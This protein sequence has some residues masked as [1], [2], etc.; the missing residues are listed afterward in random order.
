MSTGD[1]SEYVRGKIAERGV[2][3]TARFMRDGFDRWAES[4]QPAREGQMEKIPAEQQMPAVGGAMTLSKARKLYNNN[5][6]AKHGAGFKE[7]LDKIK[8]QVTS[9]LNVYRKISKFIDDFQQD[10]KDEI[11]ENPEVAASKPKLVNFAN[12]L[13]GWLESIKVYKNVLD[14]IAKMAESYGMGRKRRLTGGIAAEDIGKYAKKVFEIYSFV[15]TNAPNVRIILGLKS[16]QPIGKQILAA[17]NPLLTAITGPAPAGSGGAQVEFTGGVMKYL[18][19]KRPI[20]EGGLFEE[21]NYDDY[22]PI[23][24]ERAMGQSPMKEKP[25]GGRK[26]RHRSCECE[27][28]A[29]LKDKMVGYYHQFTSPLE[30]MMAHKVGKYKSQL[31]TAADKYLAGRTMG[32]NEAAEQAF[33]PAENELLDL[34]RRRE[35][36]ENA[37]RAA[38]KGLSHSAKYLAGKGCGGRKPSARGAIVKKVMA[39]RGLSLPQASKYVKEHGLY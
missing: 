30:N 19:D 8:G 22:R 2:G 16:L 37:Q 34:M 32:P 21:E 38:E 18:S 39:E 35:A 14:E 17:I 31:P 1:Q 13:L 6:L 27:G 28:G 29:K 26:P 3:Q 36:R 5:R 7:E 11:I 4:S 10:L 23:F 33:R 9:I 20:D 24:H 12:K 15:K 25:M